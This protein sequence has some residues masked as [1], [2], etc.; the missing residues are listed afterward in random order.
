MKPLFKVLIVVVI[1]LVVVHI[2][3]NWSW[4]SDRY[5]PWINQ[6]FETVPPGT[7]AVTPSS[8]V[9][10]A[11]LTAPPSFAVPV[12]AQPVQPLQPLQLVP[13]TY[14]PTADP[15]VGPA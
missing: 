4:Q 11:G 5:I 15:S 1:V 2:M 7:F 14:V 12:D 10:N 13:V 6:E 3:K 8:L 9:V